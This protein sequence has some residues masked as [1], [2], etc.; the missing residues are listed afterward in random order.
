MRHRGGLSAGCA[1]AGRPPKKI[2]AMMRVKNEAEFLRPSINSVID[3]VNEIGNRRQLQ[4]RWDCRNHCRFLQSISRKSKSIRLPA[5][6]R[7]LWRR[8]AEAHSNQGGKRSPSFLPNYYNWS[9]AQCAG[10]YIL[11]W[12]GDT[13]AT[14]AL[15]SPR[16][17]PTI[18]DANTMSYR[19][20][21]SCG[22]HVCHSRSAPRGNGAA[23]VLQTSLD[24]QT[25]HGI[26]RDILVTIPWH[27]PSFYEVEP[28]PLY[29]HMKFCK[30]DRS[31][32]CPMTCR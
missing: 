2:S 1:L 22:S 11:K 3:L 8:N 9:T 20:K 15:H 24:T 29:F 7:A 26:L 25:L 14:N 21:S 5:Q 17:V 31:R 18:E 27:Y 12:D 16:T 4:H 28:E 6:D 23:A 13:I 10:P 30:T 19:H 32:T